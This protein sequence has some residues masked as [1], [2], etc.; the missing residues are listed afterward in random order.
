MKQRGAFCDFRRYRVNLDLPFLFPGRSVY[1]PGNSY[2]CSQLS[3]AGIGTTTYFS[4][5]PEQELEGSVVRE[6][7]GGIKEVLIVR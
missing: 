6:Y 7:P 5:R 2:Y 3:A 1:S 4:D